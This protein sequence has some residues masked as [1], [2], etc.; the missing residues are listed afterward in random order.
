MEKMEPAQQ[1]IQ[2]P[3]KIQGPEW[4]QQIPLPAPAEVTKSAES[5]ESLWQRFQ[6]FFMSLFGAS[7][8]TVIL[9]GGEGE[10][11]ELEKKGW[12][13]FSWKAPGGYGNMSDKR[14]KDNAKRERIW[15]SPHCLVPEKFSDDLFS[16]D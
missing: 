3:A 5:H 11:E 7:A 8:A 4:V 6:I 14:G 13:I 1:L 16:E 9:H 10:H 15:F 2:P 12:T